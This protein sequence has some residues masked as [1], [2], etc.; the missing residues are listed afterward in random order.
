MTRRGRI[1]LVIALLAIAMLIALF[2]LSRP[3]SIAAIVTN[4]TGATLGLEITAGGA[5]EYRLRGTPM[6]VL[7]DVAV[8]EP[9]AERILLRA[10]RIHVAVPWSTLRAGGSELV[11]RRVELDAP[12]LDLPALQH[13]LATRPPT[14]EKRLPTLTHGLRIR[15]GEIDNDD[16]RIDGIQA[17]LPLL[18]PRQPL[19]ARLRGRYLD[20]PLSIR[21]DLT[22]AIIRPEALIRAGMTG[23]ATHGQVTIERGK[24]WN[25]PATLVLSGPLRLGAD[26]LRITPARLGIAATFEAATTRVPFALGLHGPLHFDEATWTLAPA[27]VALRRH[28]GHH[29]EPNDPIPDL[30]A[31]GTIA[32]GR[33]LTLQLDGALAQWPQAW[34]ALPP[35]LGQSQS[36]LPLNLRYDGLP[37]FV[38]VAAL[39]VRRDATRF[40]GRF[41]LPQVLEWMEQ[42]DGTPLPPLSG[43]LTTPELEISGAKLEGVQVEFDDTAAPAGESLP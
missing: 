9:G 43:T 11:A 42:K 15:D 13:W 16:W 3:Q 30:D 25:L 1:L 32:L 40:D 35:P 18:D 24:D 14:V 38:D 22:A 2:W 23:F 29:D 19:R 20:A 5:S 17:D 6:L 31:R 8:R 27:G 33:K 41:R 4:R 12:R 28:G 7:R 34:P 36:R 39:Q 21:A 10:R 37:G 26:D